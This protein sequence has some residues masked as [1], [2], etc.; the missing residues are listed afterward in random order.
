MKSII[1]AENKEQLIKLIKEEIERNGYQCD[2]NYIDVSQVTD[3]SSLFSESKFNG[4]ISKWDVSSVTNMKNLF[5]SCEFNG[6]ISNWDVSNVLSMGHMFDY[7]PFNGDISN[8]NTFN[9]VSMFEMFRCSK[10]DGDIS[11]W[12]VTKVKDM[13]MMF[14]HAKFNGDVSNWT[15]YNLGV[16]N[17]IFYKCPAK[18]PYWSLIT[19]KKNRNK[20]IDRYLLAKELN[21]ELKV[22]NLKQEKRIKI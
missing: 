16:V 9:V 15:P 11:K 2:L 4:D 1:K 7:S 5:C 12:D 10:F 18:I 6:D 8:W 13:R 20:L 19:D 22:N 21:E 3:M 17:D 14:G